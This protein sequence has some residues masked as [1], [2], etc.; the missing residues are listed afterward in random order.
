MSGSWTG[1]D[2]WFRKNVKQQKNAFVVLLHNNTIL[3]DRMQHVFFVI[4]IV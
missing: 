1:W 3:Y 4:H 2:S